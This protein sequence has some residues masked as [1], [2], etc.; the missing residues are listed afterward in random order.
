MTLLLCLVC[1][2]VSEHWSVFPENTCFPLSRDISV[3]D[4]TYALPYTDRI[5]DWNARENRFSPR[6]DGFLSLSLKKQEVARLYRYKA[7]ALIVLWDAHVFV[8]AVSPV[9]RSSEHMQ[10]YSELSGSET[11][12]W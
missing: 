6:L 8:L 5:L 3:V 2:V 12:L 9:L 11:T 1:S 4:K 7:V 10:Y